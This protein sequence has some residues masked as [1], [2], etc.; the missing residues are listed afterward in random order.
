VL[1]LFVCL[2]SVEYSSHPF[3][4]QQPPNCNWEKLGEFKSPKKS[5][6][7]KSYNL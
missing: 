6:W 1:N 2:F 3:M 7:S 5:K 4:T